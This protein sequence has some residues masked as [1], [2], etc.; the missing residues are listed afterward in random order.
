MLS[1]PYKLCSILWIKQLYK[2]YEGLCKGWLLAFVLVLGVRVATGYH[3]HGSCAWLGTPEPEPR[4]QQWGRARARPEQSNSSVRHR[5]LTAV[6]RHQQ[7]WH[8]NNNC[9]THHQW[10]QVR[11]GSEEEG[12]PSKVRNCLYHSSDKLCILC[13]EFDCFEALGKFGSRLNHIQSF[14]TLSFLEITS[15]L[16]AIIPT[17]EGDNKLFGTISQCIIGYK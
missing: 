16:V 5:S 17:S 3:E 9:D 10:Q 4:W 14:A 6:T 2:M 12:R 13:F 11:R 8:N 7:H 15:N 1:K